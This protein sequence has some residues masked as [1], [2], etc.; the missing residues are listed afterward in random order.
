MGWGPNTEKLVR[1]FL[2]A[3]RVGVG[4]QHRETGKTVSAST[5]SWG[6]GPNTEKLVR[7][8]PQ[9]QQVGVGAP[10]QRN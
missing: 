3:Q 5:A 7:Q 9:A 4:P 10:T 1:Q 6:G 8:F 2:Q